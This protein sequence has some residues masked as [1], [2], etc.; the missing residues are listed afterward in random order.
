ME[1]Y[2]H[3]GCAVG[4]EPSSTSRPVNL[5]STL[6]VQYLRIVILQKNNKKHF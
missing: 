1:A 3:L 5:Y 2:E 4:E 6:L